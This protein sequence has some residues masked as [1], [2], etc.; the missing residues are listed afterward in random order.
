MSFFE[1]GGRP[2]YPKQR[3][4]NYGLK[5]YICVSPVEQFMIATGKRQFKGYD[6]YNDL[7]RVQWDLETTGLNAEKDMIDQIGIRS[8]KGFEKVISVTGEGVDE[9]FPIS[10]LPVIKVFMFTAILLYLILGICIIYHLSL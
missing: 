5:E 9:L 4:E 7:V 6:D 2:I 8:N 1:K 10:M 3:D